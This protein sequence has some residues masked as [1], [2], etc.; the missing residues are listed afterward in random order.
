MLGYRPA[1]R[2]RRLASAAARRASRAMTRI[3]SSPPIVPTASG[4]CARSMAIASGC[5]CPTP[6]RM[7]TS[8]CTCSTRAEEL[9]GGA[10]ERGERRLGIGRVEPGPLV[11]AVAGAL[12]EAELLDVA[13]DRRL[14]RVEAAL[15][16]AAAQLLLAV[17]RV[18]I[19]EFQDDGLAARF[20][21]ARNNDCDD[22]GRAVLLLYIDF[23]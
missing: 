20:H 9:A 6:V 3:V 15:V 23:C 5:A 17:Q 2:S 8:C 1:K 12:H 4:N 19:D 10:L 21:E 18:A 14:R 11:R 7:T 22:F 13:R 16:Q